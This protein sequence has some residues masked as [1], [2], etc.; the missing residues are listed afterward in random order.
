[1]KGVTARW[2]YWEW[3][4]FVPDFAMKKLEKVFSFDAEPLAEN[5]SCD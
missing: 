5:L 3:K 2:V 4:R 1:M